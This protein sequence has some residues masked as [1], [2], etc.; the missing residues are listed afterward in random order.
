MILFGRNDVLGLFL[1]IVFVWYFRGPV[2]Y[3]VFGVLSWC[4][5]FLSRRCFCG[6]ASFKLQNKRQMNKSQTLCASKTVQWHLVAQSARAFTHSDTHK[7]LI[8]FNMALC[9]LGQTPVD[10]LCAVFGVVFTWRCHTT[11][12]EVHIFRSTQ[13]IRHFWQTLYAQANGTLTERVHL[14]ARTH[15]MV[16]EHATTP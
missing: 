12:A 14:G 1:I 15:V 7:N 3:R 2:S 6:I 16:Q 5:F 9:S 13:R 11:N 10:G 4:G 8:L